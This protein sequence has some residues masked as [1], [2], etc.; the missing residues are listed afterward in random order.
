MKFIKKQVIQESV[1]EVKEE[2][3]EQ[4]ILTEAADKNR[5]Y[6]YDSV[7]QVI[8]KILEQHGY[9]VVDDLD[10]KTDLSQKIISYDDISEEF[11]WANTNGLEIQAE[12]VDE[13]VEKIA[14]YFKLTPEEIKVIEDAINKSFGNAAGDRKEEFYDDLNTLENLLDEDSQI[15]LFSPKVK[16]ELGQL[17]YKLKHSNYTGLEKE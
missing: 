11:R 14:K 5:S 10:T 9:T 1:E 12:D 15:R 2:K 8:A 3:I 13:G 6:D 7:S 16:E 4:E 17:I